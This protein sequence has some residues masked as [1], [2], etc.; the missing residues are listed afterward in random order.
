VTS[1]HEFVEYV[2]TLWPL[3]GAEEWDSSG[4]VVGQP[5][6]QIRHVLLAVDAV[7]ATISEAVT[8][9]SDVLLTHH[10]LL[11][12]P[13]H[14]VSEDKYKGHLIAELIRND[15][16]L[17]SCHTNADVVEDGV[18]DVLAKKLG[19]KQITPII[20]GE[21][22]KEGIGRVGNLPTPTTLEDLVQKLNDIIPV[23]V[24]GIRVA[25]NAQDI[26]STIAL[27]GGAGD[28]LLYESSVMSADVYITSD[29][30]HHPTQESR[31]H[32]TLFGGPALIDISH[33][34]AESVWL[35]TAASQLRE[36]FPDI[37]FQVSALNT[38]PWNYH[39]AVNN[40]KGSTS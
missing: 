34:A 3:S 39:V 28:S 4:L 25:G 35:E 2:H 22:P 18:S 33:W 10:P 37:T 17:L 11:L 16:A 6:S 9:S 21:N 36:K 24:S 38:D 13:V 27:C 23:T 20:P 31:E 5:S 19:L 32:A 40:T 8:T 30:R 12:K 26:V 15:I 14:T 1:L 7:K 29:L